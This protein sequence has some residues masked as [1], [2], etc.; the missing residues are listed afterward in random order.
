MGGARQTGDTARAQATD[1][2]KGAR[3]KARHPPPS[4]NVG[5]LAVLALQRAAGNAAMSAL[6]AGRLRLPG[7]QAVADIDGAL[8]ELRRDE[9]AVDKVE[10]GL[11]AAKAAGVQVDL[12]GVRPPA[13]ALAV[14]TTGFGPG[15]VP[16]KK[17]VP[18]PKKVPAVSPLGRAAAK[19]AAPAG[20][21]KGGAKPAPA[22]LAGGGP[23]AAQAP[24]PLTADQLLQ[25]PVPP[26][27][28]RPE[29]DPSFTQVTSKVK[30]TAKAKRAHPPATSK[31]KEAQD[32]ALAPSGDVGSQA[33]AA[34]ADTMDAQKPGTFD[35]KA[36]I[37]AVKAA[38]E[39]K[40]PKTL[41]E[42]DNYKSSG[43][44][45]EVKDEV[46][47][48]VTEGKQGQA[49]DIEAATEAAPDQSKAV[50]KPVTPIGPEQQAPEAPIP[51][52]GAVP[53]PAPAEQLN[54]AAGK[55]QA[56][57]EMA[58]AEVSESQLAESNEPDFQQALADKKAAAAHADSA[59]GEFRQQEAQ[60]IQQGKAD[61]AAETAAGVNGMQ[62][63]KGAALAKLVA[64]KGKA[65][66]KD[67]AKR[68]EVTTKIEGIFNATEAD[69]KKILDGIDPN[70]EK[71]FNA[72]EATA[73]SVFENYVSAKMSAYKKDRYGGWLG[74]FRW[75]RDKI[76]GMPDKVNEFYVAGRELYLKEMDKVIERVANIVGT[77]LMA[78]KTRIAA[79]RNEIAAY[80][81]SLP[82]DLKK[83]GSEAS[84]EIGERFSQLESEVDSKQESLIDTL[85]SKYVEARKGLDDRIEE[86]QAENKGLVDKA[87]GAI[88]AAI[89]TIREL[90]AMLKNVLAKVAGV[91][92]Q[93]IKAPVRF[94]G[95]LIAGI[96][97]GILKFKED[98]LGHLRRGLMSWLFGA[99]AEGGIEL[100]K[101]FD[102]KGIIGFLAS[103]F[104]LTWTN[105]RNRI[106]K[107]I[108]AKAMDAVETGV[109]VFKI[110][111]GPEGVG[112]L[113]QMLLEKLG[114]IKEMI[115]EKVKDFVKDRI[116]S[117]GI[118]WLIGLLN[119]AGAFIKACKLI[120]DI[121]MF[122]V[123]NARRIEKFVDTILDSVS[124][125][126][127]GNISSVVNKINDVLG[128]MVPIIIGFL[129]SL[130]GL[131][132][133][134]AK[135]REI[136]QKLQKPV[137]QAID[138]VIKTG[139]KLAG[140]IIRGIAGI[141]SKVKAKVAA[142]KA[143]VKGKVEAGKAW[144][145]GKVEAGKAWVKGKRKD[146]P[147]PA[148]RRTALNAAMA[149]GQAA[150][151]DPRLDE[152]GIRARLATVRRDRKVKKLELVVDSRT[153]DREVVHV[154]G[155]NSPTVRGPSV[156]RWQ[157]ATIQRAESEDVTAT[158]PKATIDIEGEVY[159]YWRVGKTTVRVQAEVGDEVDINSDTSVK[160][161]VMKLVGG[162]LQMDRPQAEQ[163]ANALAS[164]GMLKRQLLMQYVSET[165]HGIQ[166]AVFAGRLLMSG[167]ATRAAIQRPV[168][169]TAKDL[170]VDK[171]LTPEQ[172]QRRGP[173][174]S[175]A[176]VFY[177]VVDGHWRDGQ[178]QPDANQAGSKSIEF[179]Y[180]PE[181]KPKAVGLGVVEI[182][183]VGTV[184]RIVSVHAENVPGGEPAFIEIMKKAGWTVE[185]RG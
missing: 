20:K 118:T 3:S 169:A 10:K 29:D 155:A 112:G 82:K 179:I 8:R 65:K 182:D 131:G 92:G 77:D 38:I 25:P 78:A 26:G 120:Y 1:A 167:T 104:G 49:K 102:P 14:T 18:P 37:T 183:D 86:L 115:F 130:I 111:S 39:A 59:P 51:A 147:S 103:I 97:G 43:K 31:A 73:R 95:N 66:T 94:L 132:G 159:T 153:K 144:V 134:G 41:T 45:G 44:A 148:E 83:V 60:V 123:N 90:V 150:I 12:E 35:K 80:V 52:A 126:V 143:W 108:G 27:R 5:P 62:S 16:A 58:D 87:I 76:K 152:K 174:T 141:S 124:E 158:G 79:G 181:G 85:A 55:Q 57:Q 109:E 125:I 89:N 30:A 180:Q 145:K 116:I 138:F 168:G 4:P 75:A 163:L 177:P 140:P 13:S 74:P 22:A 19:K 70:V 161:A 21:G 28:A 15:S 142:G 121:V 11:K 171:G 9:P 154:V 56:N 113:W 88:K 157:Q 100:P 160:A 149:D 67:E 156:I 151:T 184:F 122:F 129:A 53:K 46:K 170:L 107:Q 36:F 172:E 117:A 34:K 139:L 64:D 166:P 106:V 48:L 84:K 178:V 54:F 61:A 114:D 47:G 185:I 24:A 40:S 63:A 162:D 135:I 146:L 133:I 69:V 165:S 176:H 6:M 98:F 81:K 91:V 101:T 96:K 72:G 105:I 99:L 110:M 17:P 137:N 7:K 93:I 136:I 32:A 33:K 23:A 50:P 68:A 2:L 71:E 119:P 175:I 173:L 164:V 127:R 42:A 128:Q